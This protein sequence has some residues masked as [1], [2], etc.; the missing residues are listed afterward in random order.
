M[1]FENFGLLVF[2]VYIIEAKPSV[3]FNFQGPR[4]LLGAIC[5]PMAIWTSGFVKS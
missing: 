5:C 3:R 2:K 1:E 4:K